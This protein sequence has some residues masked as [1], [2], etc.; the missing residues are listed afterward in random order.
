MCRWPVRAPERRPCCWRKCALRSPSKFYAGCRRK[1]TPPKPYA[2]NRTVNAMARLRPEQL[3]ANLR[4]GL[5]PIYWVSGDE[6]LLVQEA[7]DTIRQAA[8]G[9]G[10]SERE[11]YHADASFD[12]KDRKSTRLNSS[13]VAISYAV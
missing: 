8:Q 5:T 6:P 11:L 4:K 3:D 7:C 10:F 1:L 2:A 9:A 13:H 12:W